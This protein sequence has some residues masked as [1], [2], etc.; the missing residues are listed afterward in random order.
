MFGAELALESGIKLREKLFYRFFGIDRM[1][2]RVRARHVIKAMGS[3][4]KRTHI[5][6]AGS[7]QGEYAFYFSRKF[8]RS[9]ITAVEIDETKIL[10]CERIR[11]KLGRDNLIFVR[12]DLTTID[13]SEDFDVILCVD[14]LEH[15]NEDK[16]AL[17]NLHRALKRGGVLLLH[18]PRNHRFYKLRFGK[19]DERATGDHVR[20]EYT[21]NEIERK[22]RETGF[23]MTRKGYT[24]GL[25]GALA[26]ELWYV[27]DRQSV[28]RPILK[29]AS[30]LLLMLGYLDGFTSN[31]EYQQGYLFM[32]TKS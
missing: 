22:L 12:G 26:W 6:D 25:F 17:E 30:P 1:G 14:V 21:E 3:I 29:L 9:Q 20:D 31:R 18:V 5:L 27:I 2:Q 11:A 7:G 13:F 4:K 32:A 24:F 8:P 19:L 10:S 16:R 15:I 28:W 23:A